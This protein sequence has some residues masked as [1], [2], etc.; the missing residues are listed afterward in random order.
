MVG[1]EGE[2]KVLYHNAPSACGSAILENL[3]TRN[4]YVLPCRQ[5][6]G[7]DIPHRGLQIVPPGFEGKTM[8]VVRTPQGQA[9]SDDPLMKVTGS[10]VLCLWIVRLRPGQNAPANL[11]RTGKRYHPSL[12]SM[13]VMHTINHARK[14]RHPAAT[15]IVSR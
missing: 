15:Y 13:R 14:A 4:L 11:F 5:V 7:H 9:R 1:A 6:Y 12:R 2:A 8:P 3:I 10:I